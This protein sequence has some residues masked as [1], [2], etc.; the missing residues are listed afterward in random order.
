MV[1]FNIFSKQLGNRLRLEKVRKHMQ[2][3]A[4]KAKTIENHRQDRIAM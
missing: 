3:S 2:R 1:S 4:V